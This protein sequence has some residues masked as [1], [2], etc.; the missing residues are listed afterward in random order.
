M[1]LL[2]YYSLTFPPGRDVKVS[3]P[4]IRTICAPYLLISELTIRDSKAGGLLV[5]ACHLRHRASQ[6]VLLQRRR[7]CV[8]G[9]AERGVSDHRSCQHQ[10]DYGTGTMQG[11]GICFHR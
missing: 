6:G 11:T 2:F 3:L 7:P 4:D 9:I 5:N 10:P 1:F 8:Q